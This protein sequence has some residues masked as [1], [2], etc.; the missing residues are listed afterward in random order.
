MD[1]DDNDSCDE[2]S[3]N[4][5]L[6]IKSFKILVNGESKEFKK[7]RKRPC[8]KCGQVGHFIAECPNKDA[9]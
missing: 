2:K 6:F 5:A 8:Y 9:K 4:T 3:D 7:G 1:D